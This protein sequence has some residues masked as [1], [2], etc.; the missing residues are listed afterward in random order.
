ME[1]LV[2]TVPTMVGS[3]SGEVSGVDTVLL[4]ECMAD[5]EVKGGRY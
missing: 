5:W 2:V 3:G 4:L 1:R